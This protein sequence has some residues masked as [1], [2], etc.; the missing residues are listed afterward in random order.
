LSPREEAADLYRRYQQPRSFEE[1]VAL[2]RVS[3]YVIDRED[4]FLMGRGVDMHAPEEMIRSPH[5]SFPRS[6]QN[7]WFIWIFVGPIN[8]MKSLAPYT[9]P[10]VGWSRRNGPIHWYWARAALGKTKPI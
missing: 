6:R 10:Y 2:H 9:L 4:V 7:A 1:D 3:G 5:V 8:L